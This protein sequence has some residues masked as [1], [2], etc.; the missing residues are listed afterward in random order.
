[1][2]ASD[3]LFVS[4]P[5]PALC[6]ALNFKNISNLLSSKPSFQDSQNIT[7]SETQ[8][9]SEKI[10]H[11]L[12]EMNFLPESMFFYYQPPVDFLVNVGGEID[13]D[14]W[15]ALFKEENI[16]NRRIGFSVIDSSQ[17]EKNNPT[18]L[19]IASGSILIYPAN[20][21]EAVLK[22]FSEKRCTLPEKWETFKKM[23]SR[24]PF[25]AL[26]ANLELLFEKLTP[27]VLKNLE[28]IEPWSELALVRIIMEK[29][30]FKAQFFSNREDFIARNKG[31]G[32]EIINFLKKDFKF[33]DSLSA[34]FS[35]KF[36]EKVSVSY[37]G[38]S[39]FLN[40]DGLGEMLEK[41]ETLYLS[42]LSEKILESFPNN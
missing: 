24:K 26:E 21:E 37:Q 29:D 1:M 9:I 22:D 13:V 25:L 31:F 27:G 39:I 14:R 41:A 8:I 7:S 20:L 23:A 5:N 19:F 16:I 38:K 33:F 42:F 17:K 2:S 40:G 35:E 15:R 36:F 18:V 34:N 30:F 6:C 11:F 4:V 28:L 12:K 3:G 32:D 10:L